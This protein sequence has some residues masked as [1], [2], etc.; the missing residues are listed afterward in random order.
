MFLLFLLLPIVTDLLH[1][2]LR[3]LS[4]WTD[5]SNTVALRC[6]VDE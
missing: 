3:G 6:H 4:L 1:G 5:P 2:L